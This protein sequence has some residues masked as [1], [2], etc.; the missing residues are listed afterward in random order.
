MRA[1]RVALLRNEITNGNGGNE[2]LS[3]PSQLPRTDRESVGRN[4]CSA[5]PWLRLNAATKSGQYLKHQKSFDNR[6]NHRDQ[7]MP[8][9]EISAAGKKD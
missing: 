2:E 7:R 4:V 1:G 3:P 5:L 6:G 9:V 8:G